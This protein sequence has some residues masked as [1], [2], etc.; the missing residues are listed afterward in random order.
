VCIRLPSLTDTVT[1]FP[2]HFTAFI[3]IFK[4]SPQNLFV[5][6]LDLFPSSIAMHKAFRQLSSI[7]PHINFT[8]LVR[9]SVR[10]SRTVSRKL[11]M[12]HGTC[13]WKI[14]L[15]QDAN[16]A[17]LC[18]FCSYLLGFKFK[19]KSLLCTISVKFEA[20]PATQILT[21][22]REDRWSRKIWTAAFAR[23][24]GNPVRAICRC[25]RFREE[26][27]LD[28]RVANIIWR[29]EITLCRICCT[30]KICVYILP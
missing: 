4:Y 25:N 8:V 7:N 27:L 6:T 11:I 21:F 2:A 28:Y 22:S 14:C 12:I 1:A 19:S 15:F 30:S 16:H 3:V 20:K 29:K 13:K 23:K 24:R 9:V 5:N 10:P 17:K 18:R 26:P